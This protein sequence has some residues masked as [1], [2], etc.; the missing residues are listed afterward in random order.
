MQNILHC[1]KGILIML[2]HKIYLIEYFWLR[3]LCLS[4]SEPFYGTICIYN[5]ERREKL[6]EDFYFS[7]VP[8]D[9]QDVSY[10]NNVEAP[11]FSI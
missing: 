2:F 10:N 11:S 7:V 3:V 8:T 1:N 9:T 6:S 5:K 4:F